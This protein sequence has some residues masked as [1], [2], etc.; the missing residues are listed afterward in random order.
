MGQDAR[1]VAGGLAPQRNAMAR[2]LI[3][4]ADDFGQTDA[5]T[6]GIA[7]AARDG[8][9]T[10]TTM[11]CNGAAAER[12]ARLAAET[13]S[14][15]VGVHLNLT[16]GRALLARELV[17]ALV[18]PDGMFRHT[19]TK[20]LVASLRAEILRQVRLELAAQIDWLI[21][22]GIQP[23][24]LDSHKHVHAIPSLF[25][26]ACGLAAER[27]IPAIRRVA[28]PCWHGPIGWRSPT[29]SRVRRARQWL[30]SRLFGVL[31]AGADRRRAG[32]AGVIVPDRFYGVMDTGGWTADLLHRLIDRLPEGV[33]ELM[34]HPGL[35][36]AGGLGRLG[37]CRPA[38][39]AALLDPG[40]RE[41]L[42]AANVRLV[43]FGNFT[44]GNRA[45]IH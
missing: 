17:P 10:S 33:S 1:V 15:G 41:H 35:A 20:W 31:F 26:I 9:L 43:H 39:L 21:S 11:L 23:T 37:R 25:A 5:I 8:I 6:D 16:Q 36:A 38:E 13:P 3:I 34:V 14:L 40:I 4:N 45:R 12:A 22:R 42:A 27:N 32:R 28:E 2:Y 19:P 7:Q 24:H 30:N 44:T 18:R 29:L